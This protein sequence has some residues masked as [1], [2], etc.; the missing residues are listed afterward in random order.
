MR[1]CGPPS[2]TPGEAC[3]EPELRYLSGSLDEA[4]EVVD[5]ESPSSRTCC[6]GHGRGGAVLEGF[7]MTVAPGE[8]VALVSPSGSGELDGGRP[9]GPPFRPRFR[10]SLAGREGMYGTSAWRELR[11]N[12]S[13]VDQTALSLQ[14]LDPGER[15]VSAAGGERRAEVM[16]A[17]E[18]AGLSDFVVGLPRRARHDGG[19][20]RP[21]LSAGGGN[22]WRSRG[23]CWPT[24]P[25]WCW[26]RR[27]TA[28]QVSSQRS[29]LHVLRVKNC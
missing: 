7:G 20:G 26:T 25:C 18:R 29:G 8:V 3:G 17:V 2:P 1:P 15:A 21:Q 9:D 11:A 23:R 14:H 27:R 12:V 6:A 5:A 28:P 13:L 16:Q 4:I 19:R 22:A 24:R 10:A